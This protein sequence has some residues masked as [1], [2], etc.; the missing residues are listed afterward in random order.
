MITNNAEQKAIRQN[1]GQKYEIFEEFWWKIVMS[2]EL[3][4]GNVDEQFNYDSGETETCPR[5]LSENQGEHADEY[6]GVL[7][8]HVE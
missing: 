8:S 7:D 4:T 1:W 5:E 6:R 2:S 3:L